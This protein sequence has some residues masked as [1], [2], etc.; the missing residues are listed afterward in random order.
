MEDL[1][2]FLGAS[3]NQ[4][5]HSFNSL[6]NHPAS[7]CPSSSR[8]FLCNG[9]HHTLLHSDDAPSPPVAISSA[10]AQ[11][12]ATRVCKPTLLATTV[13]RVTAPHGN[14]ARVRALLDQGS[15]ATFISED[16]A[17][18][19]KLR[20]S[21]VHIPVFGMGAA[22]CGTVKAMANIQLSSDL[23]GYTATVNAGAMVLPQ[24][25]TNI[26][27]LQITSS[28]WPHLATLSLSDSDPSS[29]ANIDLV[30]GADLYGLIL[31][32]GLIKGPPVSSL[33]CS[34]DLSL[35][36][37]FRRFWEIE[38]IPTQTLVT[39]K[40]QFCQNHFETTHAR[41][42]TGKLV[43]RL[44]RRSDVPLGDSYSLALRSFRRGELQRQRNPSLGLPKLHGGV[45]SVRAH[46]TDC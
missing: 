45:Y 33:H 21:R 24:L 30:I 40:D 18:R 7:S 42:A 43:V 22:H 29:S 28:S 10:H 25:M 27:P 39:P 9:D 38:E 37:Q 46:D 6:R 4:A 36:D 34:V 15:E 11:T 3:T 12:T 41:D 35:T 20:R 16:V 44:P 2:D 26:R 23:E 1:I 14:S 19:L 32:D 31:L 5:N 13:A 8:C 17:Q